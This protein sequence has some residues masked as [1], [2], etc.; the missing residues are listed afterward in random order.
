[1]RGFLSTIFG[2][3]DSTDCYVRFAA[4]PSPRHPS[5]GHSYIGE[6]LPAHQLI[7]R[8]GSERFRAHIERWAPVAGSNDS[9]PGAKR[10]R[11]NSLAAVQAGR[12]E[13]GPPRLRVRLSVDG[14]DS[15]N[16]AVRDDS[17]ALPELLVPLDSEDDLQPAIAA[18]RF[19]YSG[20]LV[21]VKQ[22]QGR[23]QTQAQ[24]QP[25]GGRGDGSGVRVDLSVSELLR[26]RRQAEYLQ[27]HGCTEVCDAAL[28]DKYKKPA[29]SLSSGSGTSSASP[30]AP[31]L[32]LYSC[33]HLLPSKEEDARIKPVLSAC[34]RHL[35]RHWAAQLPAGPNGTAEASKVEVLVW[36]MGIGDAVRIAN[37]VHLLQRWVRLPAAVLEDLLQSDHLSTDDE[38]TVVMLVELW[39][40]TQVSSMTAADMA[41]LRRQL[42]LV[43]C[44]TSYLFDVLPKLPWLGPDPVQQAVFLARCRLSDRSLWQQLGGPGEGYDTSSPWYG[45]PRPQSA[46][47]EGVSYRWQVSRGDLLAGLR[48]EGPTKTIRATFQTSSAAQH[49]VKASGFKWTLQLSYKPPEACFR[50]QLQCDIFPPFG[51]R[52]DGLQGGGSICAGVQVQGMAGTRELGMTNALVRY[53][54]AWDWPDALPLLAVRQGQGGGEAGGDAW[55]L[56]PWGELLGAEEKVTGVLTLGRPGAVVV[57]G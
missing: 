24:G 31:V 34:Q 14:P 36:L 7:L 30:L 15:E 56:A 47:E 29:P 44:N 55:L 9:L 19:I 32:E 23:G 53:S 4:T 26:I 33:R 3:K 17:P 10:N 25:E 6:P 37:D 20:S 12:E 2:S 45:K 21:D 35:L 27:V 42:R 54:R 22:E 38:A 41:R 5:P 46:P 49:T 43:N 40:L 18:I 50:V 48:K 57:Q 13:E 16:C 11:A 52:R 51:A 39:E 8:A 28:L 1:M